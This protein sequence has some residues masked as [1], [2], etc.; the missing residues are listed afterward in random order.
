MVVRAVP[1]I[2]HNANK[3]ILI[4]LLAQSI[5]IFLDVSAKWLSVAGLPTNQIMFARYGVH[6]GLLLLLVLPVQGWNLLRSGNWK[7]E[8]A[9][10]LCLLA[11]RPAI[12]SPCAICR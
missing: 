11:P 1:A 9:R 7:L 3:A 6:V 12:S 8:V 4:L 5:L 10:G 2:E